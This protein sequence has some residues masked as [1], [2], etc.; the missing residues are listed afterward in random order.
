MS[1]RF[2]LGVVLRLRE[3]A[4]EAARIELGH[5]VEAHRRAVSA[6]EAEQSR[7]ADEMRFLS[8]L[9]RGRSQAVALRDAS[10]AVAVAQRGVVRARERLDRASDALFA[11][12][13]SLADATRRREVVERL[14]DRFAAAQRREADRLDTLAMAEIASTRH[15]LRSAGERR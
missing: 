14:R 15:A 9:Q 3:M 12:R 2:R 8:A 5:A 1:H 4:E 10:N 11:A 6:L 7:A 13:R